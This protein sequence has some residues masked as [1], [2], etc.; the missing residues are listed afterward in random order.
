MQT[1][2]K[3]RVLFVD[4]EPDLLAAIAR[5]LRSEHFEV[6]TAL[7]AAAAL[8]TMEKAG[9][10]AVVVSDLRMPEMDGVALLRRTREVFPDTVRVLFTGQPDLDHAIAAVNEGAIFRFVTKPC[11]RV[12]LAL[13]LKGAVE[14]HRLVTAERELLQQ[15]LRGSIKALTDV[16]GLAS[17]LAFGRASR[18]RQTAA[19]LAAALNVSESWHVEVAAMLSQI[20]SIALPPATLERAYQGEEMSET[21]LEMMRRIP[22]VTE[23]VLENIPRLDPVLEI[24]RCQHK[25]FD[26]TGPPGGMAGG[27]A[28]PWGARALKVA[29]DIDILEAGGLSPSL[30][31]DTLRGREGWYDPA[32]VEAL[33]EVRKTE[34]RFKVRELP[35]DCLSVGMVLAQNIR[36]A[37]GI[38]FVARGQEVTAGLIEKF[39][40]SYPGRFHGEPVRVILPDL[41]EESVAGR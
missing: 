29:T 26:G 11:S 16:L 20:G 25:H 19:S 1:P 33:S 21:E 2:S 12:V 10:F 7:S 27:E 39:R 13:T 35:L 18:L 31:V 41:P 24:L 28:I 8:E 5:N 23:Q 9:P 30:A 22:R 32:I 37:K 36:T 4:D 38:L 15:T 6:T 40:N 3:P 17:P 34:R 14:Q